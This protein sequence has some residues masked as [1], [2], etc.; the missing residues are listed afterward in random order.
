MRRSIRP[1]R[2]LRQIFVW[3]LVI[4]LV[5]TIGLI[6]A[7]VGDGVWDRLSWA[8]LSLPVIAAGWFST[9]T[10]TP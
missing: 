4:G 10:K 6:A 3:P 8:A 2:T 7:L 1:A 5:T 9:R